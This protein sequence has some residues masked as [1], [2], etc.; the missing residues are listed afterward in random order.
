VGTDGTNNFE[1]ADQFVAEFHS[2]A[3]CLDVTSVDH[4]EGTGGKGCRVMGLSV[5]VGVMVRP[6]LL[7]IVG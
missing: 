2:W 5:G 1:R 3:G 4:Y 7:G 6:E